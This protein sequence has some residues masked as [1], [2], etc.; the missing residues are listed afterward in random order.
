MDQVSADIQA[1]ENALRLFFQ[2]MKRP[3]RWAEITSRAGVN[4]D[5]PAG[6]IVLLLMGAAAK[7]YH[8]QDLANALAI[9]APS[10]TRKTQ[11]LEKAGYLE[12]VP[13]PKDG[14]AVTF[15]LTLSGQKLG[16]RLQ[17]AQR[18]FLTQAL[19]NWSASDRQTFVQLFERFS[20]D[21]T[22]NYQP[23]DKT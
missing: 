19:V 6:V 15:R 12:R 4:I 1:L 9:E 17:A 14:R 18:E 23:T 22:I 2:T 8:L 13:D 7:S 10:A 5:R 3:Q 11:E 16:K 21:M 20:S